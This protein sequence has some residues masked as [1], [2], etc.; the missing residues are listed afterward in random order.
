MDLEEILS[1]EEISDMTLADRE[2]LATAVKSLE[3]PNLAARLT[4]LVGGRQNWLS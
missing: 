1:L 4:N 2:A 3:R